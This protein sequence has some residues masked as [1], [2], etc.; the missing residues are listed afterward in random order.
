VASRKTLNARNLEA[1]GAQR[2]AELL[3]EVST[4][5]AAVKR[6]LRLELAGA[7][8][9]SDVSKEVRKRL[10][11]IARSRSFIDWQN[12][13]TLV[14]DLESQRRAI[15]NQVAK[16]DLAEALE[17]TWR[18]M[19]LCSF[20]SNGWN[21]VRSSSRDRAW[22]ARRIR[23]SGVRVGSS[24][25]QIHW[26]TPRVISSMGSPYAAT[27]SHRPKKRIVGAGMLADLSY[28]G[29]RNKLRSQRKKFSIPRTEW[30]FSAR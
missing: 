28:E 13:R 22:Q 6:R 23:E 21:V 16:A 5:N 26:L 10:A 25:G 9:P 20:H 3:I 14:E 29:R 12:R 1:L 19:A 2:L 4:A 30:N 17:L 15:V 27:V 8:S 18:F 24:R 7:Q 11:T